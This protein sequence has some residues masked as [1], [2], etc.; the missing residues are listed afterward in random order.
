MKLSSLSARQRLL[1]ATTFK[2]AAK[3]AL[4]CGVVA[5]ILGSAASAQGQ[6]DEGTALALA[7][8]K[9]SAAAGQFSGGS[10]V[11]TRAYAD[12]AAA[13]SALEGGYASAVMFDLSGPNAG[14]GQ[15]EQVGG[16]E[17]VWVAQGPGQTLYV[18][19][20]IKM[21]GAAAGALCLQLQALITPSYLPRYP[22]RSVALIST[23]ELVPA[24]SGTR[25][26]AQAGA[27]AAGLPQLP[28][29]VN[30][31]PAEITPAEITPAGVGLSSAGGPVPVLPTSGQ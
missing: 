14:I 26:Q 20:R 28:E 10:A 31:R 3:Q 13:M 22:V 4:L 30:T 23:G 2:R 27:P 21:P 18:L 17:A 1:H 29:Q 16:R 7:C 6:G 12:G 24:A 9:A 25:A 11:F 8:G 15:E 19:S 5:G